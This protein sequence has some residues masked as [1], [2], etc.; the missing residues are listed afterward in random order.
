MIESERRLIAAFWALRI[1]L[2]LGMLAAGLDK[3]ANLL[4]DWSMYLS[5]LAERLLPVSGHA[6]MRGAGILEAL[7]GLAILTRFTRPAAYLMTA[8][9]LAIAVNLAITG[10]FWDLAVRDTEISIAAFVLGRLGEWR[11]AA[12]S[13][14]GTAEEAVPLR[15]GEAKA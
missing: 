7:L 11:A 5:P 1:G 14:A 9:M 10:S 2:G 13:A 3:F 15:H 8:W 12:R 6:F 4:T